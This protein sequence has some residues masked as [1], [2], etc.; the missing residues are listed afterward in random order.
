MRFLPDCRLGP[1]ANRLA[2][3][4]KSLSDRTGAAF[5]CAGGFRKL[6]R[7]EAAHPASEFLVQPAMQESRWKV[8]ALLHLPE[9]DRKRRSLSTVLGTF[10]PF[11]RP[12]PLR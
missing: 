4:R 3:A 5:P 10:A 11:V 8:S 9:R 12:S 1:E 2:P 6:P 7:R